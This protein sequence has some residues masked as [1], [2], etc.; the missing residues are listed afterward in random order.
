MFVCA[1]VCVCVHV[2]VC[3]RV[4]VCVCA[5]VCVRVSVCECVCVCV[6]GGVCVGVV[7]RS[8]KLICIHSYM[9]TQITSTECVSLGSAG[10][11]LQW[12]TQ[13]SS[14][15]NNN[16]LSLQNMASFLTNTLQTQEHQNV[17]KFCAQDRPYYST[18]LSLTIQCCVICLEA[19]P[20]QSWT[21]RLLPCFLTSALPKSA[22]T[23]GNQWTFEQ[24]VILVYNLYFVCTVPR[25]IQFLWNSY[26]SIFCKT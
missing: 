12:L 25:V 11:S 23:T 1:C 18:L 17:L 24:P 5:G 15:F 10:N 6:D 21:R 8:A 22:I 19:S 14:I 20:R 26:V 13:N 4:Y 16:S 9:V 7:T 3:V 2:C